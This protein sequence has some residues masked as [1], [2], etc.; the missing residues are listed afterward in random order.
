[1]KSKNSKRK[2]NTDAIKTLDAAKQ[3]F[4]TA[5]REEILALDAVIE[6]VKQIMEAY[7][8][9]PAAASLSSLLTIMQLILNTVINKVIDPL[10]MGKM[11]ADAGEILYM[12][13]SMID[14]ELAKL[15]KVNPSD[16]RLQVLWDLKEIAIGKKK[17]KV[18]KKIKR[19]TI[20]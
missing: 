20:K 15:E 18:A 1:M 14:E 11:P 9:V 19:I 17:Q 4:L 10:R 16:P 13:N 8:D 12:V 7:D 5:N 6:F 3:H 2:L